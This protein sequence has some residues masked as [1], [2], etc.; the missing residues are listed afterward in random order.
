[1][2]TTLVRAR[3][4]TIGFL[5]RVLLKP[6]FFARDPEAVH[7]RM[8]AAGAW[9][10]R[11]AAGRTLTRAA[12]FYS[13]PALE[14]TVAGVRFKNPVGLSAGFD[15]NARLTQILPDVGFGFAE[16]GSVTGEA[17]AGNPGRRLW[18]LPE[19]Q[20]LA[21]YYGLKNDGCEAIAARL[22]GLPQRAVLGISIAKTNSEA[23]V[24]EAAGIADYL[25]A[26]RTFVRAGVGDYYTIN[27]SCPNA[28]GGEPFTDPG[29]LDR[30]LKSLAEV[31]KRAPVFLKLPAELP[32]AQ[33]DEIVAVCRRY[34]VDGF[35]CT[36]LAKRRDNPRLLDANIPAVG[37]FSGKVVEDLSNRLISRLYRSCG[38]D[39]VL[40]GS[41]GVFSAEDAYKK[42]RL[43]A[44]LVQL[45]TGMVYRGPQLISSINVGLTGLL[46]RDGF[47]N[48]AEAVGADHR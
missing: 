48:L 33:V 37:G 24:D 40:V 8:V 21:V 31:Q 20:S 34:P 23:T 43:G 45:I 46:A 6:F 38:A 9:L 11:S 7:D 35:V 22:K 25:K 16:V 2:V 27:V 36:N 41:G 14:Q 5:Y 3:N 28:F 44:S 26:Y 12:F 29:K 13:S 42:I 4:A 15:K 32:D 39:F 30:L 19:S 10:G 17:C 47:T 1:M 18:R